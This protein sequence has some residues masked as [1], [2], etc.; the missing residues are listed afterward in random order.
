MKNQSDDEKI[1]NISINGKCVPFTPMELYDAIP[2]DE[3]WLR[4]IEQAV[5]CEICYQYYPINGSIQGAE[6]GKRNTKKTFSGI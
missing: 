3:K 6:D 2:F 5:K 1:E 4:K